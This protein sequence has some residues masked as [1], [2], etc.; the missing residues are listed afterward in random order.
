MTEK[1][2]IEEFLEMC[3][4]MVPY[5]KPAFEAYIKGKAEWPARL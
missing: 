5:N 2:L 1:K 3:R 4:W